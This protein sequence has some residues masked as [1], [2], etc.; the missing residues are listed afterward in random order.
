MVTGSKVRDLENDVPRPQPCDIR[1]E[2]GVL[3]RGVLLLR[4]RT[5]FF[6][7]GSEGEAGTDPKFQL[8]NL[9]NRCLQRY[10]RFRRISIFGRN[11]RSIDRRNERRRLEIFEIVPSP[12]VASRGEKN[13][14]NIIQQLEMGERE[15]GGG[16]NWLGENGEKARVA[17]ICVCVC[18][19]DEC[20]NVAPPD[21]WNKGSEME[22]NY[23]RSR[24]SS[25]AFRFL[26]DPLA[27]I[28]RR[29]GRRTTFIKLRA[30]ART[31]G[32][33]RRRRRPR[34]VSITGFLGF[35]FL[36]RS[37]IKSMPPRS[38]TSASRLS[39]PFLPS[40]LV[41]VSIYIR[42]VSLLPILE[43]EFY[44]YISSTT[45]S[46]QVQFQSIRIGRCNDFSASR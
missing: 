27:N 29:I 46:F 32:M 23:A 41:N 28:I 40:T 10:R 39:S 36:F 12:L 15:Q 19:W 22:S 26:P 42:V 5:S 30:T 31:R 2:R 34:T 45:P 9:F 14:R 4:G 8:S 35:R 17:E 7:E 37:S 6:V 38:K 20:Q 24:V 1:G 44:I 33:G 11:I 25:P 16:E 3:T 13:M 43:I 18:A 21:E